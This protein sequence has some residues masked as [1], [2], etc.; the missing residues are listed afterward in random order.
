MRPLKF[1]KALQ[2]KAV[3]S[4]ALFIVFLIMFCLSFQ[5]D[6]SLPAFTGDSPGQAQ[7][8]DGLIR[9]PSVFDLL[10]RRQGFAKTL[11][12]AGFP[13][14]AYV[15]ELRKDSHIPSIP[16][17]II[18][19]FMGFTPRG[20]ED[21]VV[22][23]F[24]RFMDDPA[25]L[26]TDG[27]AWDPE[28][29]WGLSSVLFSLPPG[30]NVTPATIITGSSPVVAIYHTHATESYLP[31]LKKRSASDAFTDDMS[32]SVVKVGDML[33]WELE[34][35]YR[36]PVLHSKTV[37]DADSRLGAYYR[38]EST[39]MAMREKYPDCKI[40]IDIHRDSQPRSLTAVTIGGKAYARM[41]LVV[42]TENPNWVSNYNFSRQIIARLEERHP[43]ITRGILY[44]S[45][46][47]NQKYSP[48]AILVEVGGVDNALAECKNSMEALAWALASVI[49]GVKQ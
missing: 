14:I 47:Y 44:A 7:E 16:V 46:V 49:S 23:N 8:G 38:S 29:D 43:G 15:E 21:L 41:L 24:P 39:V 37:H 30:E 33:A 3:L 9:T 4:Q 11:L 25:M 42:G 45:A 31:E 40:L 19:W 10:W 36:L 1:K 20:I 6:T 27:G 26:L 17:Q 5:K 32:K 13:M 48:L 18:G 2:I 35:K 22:S 12:K 28:K 34:Q